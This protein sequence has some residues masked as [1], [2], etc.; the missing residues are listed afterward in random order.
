MHKSGTGFMLLVELLN[1]YYLALLGLLEAWPFW[2]SKNILEYPL[3][4]CCSRYHSP[5]IFQLHHFPKSCQ[6]LQSILYNDFS[7][8]CHK[9]KLYSKFSSNMLFN[10]VEMNI[11]F[12]SC[13]IFA[14]KTLA[15]NSPWGCYFTIYIPLITPWE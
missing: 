1:K 11:C 13:L 10:I 4:L 5:P 15:L 12:V 9:F 14:N 2:F 6:K 7:N 8:L 3:E